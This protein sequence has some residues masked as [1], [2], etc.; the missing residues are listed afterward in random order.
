MEIAKIDKSNMRQVILDFPKQFGVG[1]EAAKKVKVSDFRFQISN[2]IVC[3]VGG[4]AL[5]A[6]ILAIWL[7]H[8]K[9]TLPLQIH[10][11]YG[12]PYETSKNNLVFCISY[13]GN[14]EETLSAFKEA[15]KKRLKI[16]AITSGGKLAELCK[17]YSIPTAIIPSGLQP[18]VALGFQF[19]ALMK[20]LADSGLI[21]AK[22]EDISELESL[23]KPAFLENQGRKIAERLM[24]KIPL[25]YAS[26]K[27]AALAR[28]WKIKFNENSKIPA[29]SNYFPELNHN[30]HCQFER[31][32]DRLSIIILR[33]KKDYPMILKRME[34]TAQILKERGFYVDIVD[35]NGYNI[36]NKI[37]SNILLADWASYHLALRQGIDPTP[38]ALNDEFKKRLSKL[39][40]P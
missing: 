34:L 40:G 18:R 4:S 10:R 2:L 23:L 6:D 15:R 7:K 1:L 11:N 3:G 25:I 31:N 29:F 17:K 39:N 8:N 36:L 20:I 24:D 27:L 38:V 14:T 32:N 16:L 26:E 5:P 33:D 30:E 19:A 35:I 28:I 37:F 21:K 9:I 12:L 22:L 13:S